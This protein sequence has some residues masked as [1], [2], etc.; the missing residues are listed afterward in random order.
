LF[1]L[2]RY[3][4]CSGQD[5]TGRRACLAAAWLTPLIPTVTSC[6]ACVVCCTLRAISDVVAFCSSTATAMFVEI[7]LT[8]AMVVEIPWIAS[9]A[10]LVAA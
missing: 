2:L 4:G 3:V 5:L 9:T 1:G 6:A 7:A 10:S 8:S